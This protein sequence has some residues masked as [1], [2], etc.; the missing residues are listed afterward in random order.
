MQTMTWK[1]TRTGKDMKLTGTYGF[2]L[3]RAMMI[4]QVFPN[5][6]I[7]INELPI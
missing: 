6:P 1:H 3:I 7:F 5:H 2:L 4:R